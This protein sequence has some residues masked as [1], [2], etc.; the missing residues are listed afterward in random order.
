[1]DTELMDT[2]HMDTV[3]MDTVHMDTVHHGV[4]LLYINYNV[5]LYTL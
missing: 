2:V 4:C 5:A 3:H 1:M